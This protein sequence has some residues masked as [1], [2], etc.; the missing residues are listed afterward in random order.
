MI[1]RPWVTQLNKSLN[2]M[3]QAYTPKT[4]NFGGTI[5][6]CTRVGIAAGILALGYEAFWALVFRELNVDMD[7]NFRSTLQARDKKKAGK[8][9]IQNSIE[10]KVRRRKTFMAKFNEAHKEQ[11]NDAKTGKTY[12]AGVAIKVAT[13]KAK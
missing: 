10:E 12:G 1:A 5:S 7:T 11:M 13:K 8:R 4:K 6:L 9:A 3:V 2:N